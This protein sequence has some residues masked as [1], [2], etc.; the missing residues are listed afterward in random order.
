MEYCQAFFLGLMTCL[1][2]A[3]GGGGGGGAVSASSAQGVVTPAPEPEISIATAATASATREIQVP[4]GF[5]LAANY[6]VLLDVDL[7]GEYS[8]RIS[9]SV[10]TDFLRKDK[11]V[12]VDYD[13]CLL[14]AS[15]RNGRFSSE[16][17]VGTAQKSLVLVIGY[18]DGPSGVDHRI[19][20]KVDSEP[21]IFTVN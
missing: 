20:E 2:M 19:W 3:C 13:S 6:T 4:N 11:S 5:A 17:E 1:M 7:E 9:L 10:C 14:K 21:Y 8:H 18:F 12:Q 15:T 16:L